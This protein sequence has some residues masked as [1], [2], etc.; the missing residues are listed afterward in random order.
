MEANPSQCRIR[1]RV[2]IVVVC[3]LIVMA[4]VLLGLL[5]T[6]GRVS[7]GGGGGTPTPSTTTTST[8]GDDPSPDGDDPST[9]GDDPT[10]PSTDGD[11]PIVTVT[12]VTTVTPSAQFRVLVDVSGDSNLSVYTLQ[13]AAFTLD[14]QINYPGTRWSFSLNWDQSK[15]VI[16]DGGNVKIFDAFDMS[17]P[18]VSIAHTLTFAADVCMSADG[19]YIFVIKFGSEGLSIID[20]EAKQ[21]LSEMAFPDTPGFLGVFRPRRVL[22]DPNEN[23]VYV[24]GYVG[25][26]VALSANVRKYSNNLGTLTLVSQVTMY[27]DFLQGLTTSEALSFGHAILSA[28]STSMWYAHTK[29]MQTPYVGHYGT[30]ITEIVLTPLSLGR[31]IPII[32]TSSV[33][34]QIWM[35]HHPS[36]RILYV[37]ITSTWGT[38]FYTVDLN[39]DLPTPLIISSCTVSDVTNSRGIQIQGP[40]LITACTVPLQIMISEW[41]LTG[42]QPDVLRIPVAN[43]VDVLSLPSV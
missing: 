20:V 3:V 28:D 41:G 21:Q 27:P 35:A 1:L 42:V 34:P 7:G 8:D 19:A 24:Y 26:T 5:L 16:G 43:S 30:V 4:S 33:F 29:A 12:P 22:T 36:E 25:A 32:Y 31:T 11:D 6:P 37:Q 14:S 13:D 38:T 23:M 18:S 39:P 40:Y 17:Q 9:D 2:G 10:S 15:I